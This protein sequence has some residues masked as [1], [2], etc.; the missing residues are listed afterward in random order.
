MTVAI[1]WAQSPC[2]TV[3]GRRYAVS[4][5]FMRWKEK[6]QIIKLSLVWTFFQ[7]TQGCQNK[8]A[9][10]AFHRPLWKMRRLL[11]ILVAQFLSMKLH[12]TEKR[13]TEQ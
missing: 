3:D 6:Q 13:K 8:P 10:G 9:A 12:D 7:I 2:A 5:I 1:I 11:Y 4:I